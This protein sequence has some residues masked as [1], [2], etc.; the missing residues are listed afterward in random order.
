MTNKMVKFSDRINEYLKEYDMTQLAFAAKIGYSK[1]AVNAWCNGKS[2]PIMSEVPT[3]ADKMNVSVA[4][5][6]GFVNAP[7]RNSTEFDNNM[8][9]LAKEKIADQVVM[10]AAPR[11]DINGSLMPVYTVDQLDKRME[12]LAR[13]LDMYEKKLI[14]ADMLKLIVNSL[15]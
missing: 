5:L 8:N 11:M 1:Q 12:M 4:W 7:M 14:D 15:R 3:L 9:E 13:A 6:M 2:T 10:D